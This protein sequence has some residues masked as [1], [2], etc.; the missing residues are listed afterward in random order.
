MS[1]F[2]TCTGRVI[3]K[4]LPLTEYL[5]GA[6]NSAVFRTT[7]SGQNAAI[8]L[9][10]AVPAKTDAQLAHLEAAA[11]LSHPNLLRILHFGRTQ[12]DGADFIYVVTEFAEE[13][14][15]QVLPDRAL[16]V[17]ETQQVLAT[18]LGVLS[19]LHEQGFVHG[20]LKP[21]NVMAS[22][23]QLK[24]SI[25]GV[26]RQGEPLSRPADAHD[27]PE[28]GQSLTPASDIWSLGLTL[29]EVLTQKL[30]AKS[31]SEN[32]G[33]AVPEAV[34]PPF[35]EIA[36]H[37][38]L[39]TPE[40]RWGVA[41]IHNKLEGRVPGAPV[42]LETTER[43]PA[44][45]GPTDRTGTGVHL[46]KNRNNR[47]SSMR[48]YIMVAI[49]AVVVAAIVFMPRLGSN[50][51]A[52]PTQ[53]S[54]AQHATESPLPQTATAEA[55]TGSAAHDTQKSEVPE[56]KSAGAGPVEPVAT[57]ALVHQPV[58]SASNVK[59]ITDEPAV[60][61]GEDSPGTT[62]TSS[63][64]LPGVVHQAMP[65]V[66]PQAER[67]ISGKVRVKVRVDVDSAGSVVDSQFVSA[68]PSKYFS[69]TAMDAARRWKFASAG[70]EARTYDIEFTFRRSGTEVRASQQH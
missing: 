33:P 55:N 6:S 13:N 15:S 1:E 19:Y 61:T 14:L 49:V 29:V 64:P 44:P 70:T 9:L 39:R 17:P 65:A 10:A 53:P 25:D 37:C 31:A 30:P 2:S 21:A 36:Q 67:S 3:D 20:D 41:E 24:L 43:V 22:N 5:G 8:K 23:D 47:A 69:R 27:A 7:Y 12:L 38:L 52:Q 26:H 66:I 50:Q 48:P 60:D 68:G 28:A 40:L 54:A 46:E 59:H 11:K 57:P 42:P 56:S 45:S 34:P 51:S 4:D 63:A 35:R 58:A 16:T 32:A 18:A 62:D